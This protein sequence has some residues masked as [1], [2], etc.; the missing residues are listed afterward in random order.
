MS[1]EI[2]LEA[3]LEDEKDFHGYCEMLQELCVA[4]K[5]KMET[6]ESYALIDIC[7]EGFV[8]V[9]YEEGYLSISSQTNVAG[10]GFHA[11]V[12]DF[13]DAI[14]EKSPLE[15]AV[16][17]PTNYFNDR[18]FERLKTQIFYRWLQDIANYVQEEHE[19]C[20]NLCISWPMY[21]YQPMQKEGMVVTPMGYLAI[22]QFKE[23]NI[24]Q[25]AQH[26]FVW[27]EKGRNAMYYRNAALNLLW[28]ECFYEYSNMNE[29][30]EKVADMILDYLE[31]AHEMDPELPIPF[32]EYQELCATIYR[33]PRMEQ[34]TGM[35]IA[36][37]GYR[38]NEVKYS[39]GNW[40][41]T[42]SGCCEKNMDE[43]N[44][45]L[46]LMA[47]YKS[48]DEPWAWMIK[49][50]GFAFTKPIET[51]LPEIVQ[52]EDALEQFS[53]ENDNIKGAA[54]LE[55]KEDHLLLS[56]QCNCGKEMLLIQYVI[57]DKKD[58]SKCKEQLQLIQ[59]R[60]FQDDK[61]KS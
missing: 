2:V 35:Y 28:K 18:N 25:L 57:C 47:P 29:S 11:Y 26:F 55:Q 30:T 19:T 10:P 6:F 16:S 58:V 41:I 7:P 8:E 5:L 40:N 53:F 13:F 31:I 15:L 34:A 20:E 54:V 17:D 45:T 43:A 3:Q 42:S 59:H 39:F 14:C 36:N 4:W 46:Y 27:N 9:G 49:V 48:A 37:I 23:E 33:T 22:S 1:I 44:Q 52:V 24:D 56:A 12:C 51:F 60:Q 21:Y 61:L 32:Q 38:K 50:N